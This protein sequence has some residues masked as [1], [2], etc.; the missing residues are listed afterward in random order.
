MDRETRTI[1]IR[2]EMTPD[3]CQLLL[4]GLGELVQGRDEQARFVAEDCPMGAAQIK[5]EAD[6]LRGLKA[7]A[8]RQFT[9]C[10][11]GQK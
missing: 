5:L 8:E 7:E 6:I 2:F 9:S 3:E 1:S 4:S 10:C 11:G